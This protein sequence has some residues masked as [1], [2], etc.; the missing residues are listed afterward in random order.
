MNF[1]STAM[2]HDVIAVF[3]D[4]PG[5]ALA[6]GL[7]RLFELGDSIEIF[8]KQSDHFVVIDRH[9]LTHRGLDIF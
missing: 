8:R 9:K 4:Q 5:F 1:L 7:E 6:N 3:F 2:R